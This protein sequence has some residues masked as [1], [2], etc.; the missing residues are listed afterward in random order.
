[1]KITRH[2]RSSEAIALLGKE[3]RHAREAA[4]LSQSRVKDM[5]QGTISKM[6]N[7]Q[8]VTLDTFLAYAAS[9]GLEVALVPYG[10]ATALQPSARAKVDISSPQ[11]PQPLDLLAEFDNL[12]DPE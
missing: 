7:G 4:G 5:R 9:L 10:R 1:M 6:E 2:L 11:R 3:L 8:D 12:K